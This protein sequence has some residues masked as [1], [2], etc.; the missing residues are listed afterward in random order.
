M[1]W[2]GPRDW[3][4]TGARAHSWV[5]F[6]PKGSQAMSSATEPQRGESRQLGERFHH[7]ALVLNQSSNAGVL[8]QQQSLKAYKISLQN[9]P[10]RFSYAK[11][12]TAHRGNSCALSAKGAGMNSVA[13]GLQHARQAAGTACPWLQQGTQLQAQPGSPP[14]TAEQ[15]P[16]A[17]S[18]TAPPTVCCSPGC[19]MMW[20][21]N[22]P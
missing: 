8:P 3:T 21:T 18:A 2:S 19:K 6:H 14:C 12:M 16:H 9:P 22:T 11:S 20:S 7:H 10:V 4:S 17:C 15:Y 13:T 1:G 5:K